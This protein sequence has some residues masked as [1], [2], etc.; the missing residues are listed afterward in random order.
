M[1]TS[2]RDHSCAVEL[3]RHLLTIYGGFADKR[4]KNLDKGNRFIVDDRDQGQTRDAHGQLYPWFC[5]MALEVISPQSMKLTMHGNVPTSPSVESWID[6][7]NAVR[8][9]APKG[10]E[11]SIQLGE[12]ARL[13]GL[14]DLIDAIVKPPARYSVPSYKYVCPRTATALRTLASALAK[15][16]RS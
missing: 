3:K 9:E 5:Q 16:P 8:I 15:A 1:T 13:V 10:L 6:A 4:I 11:L 2:S 7:N 14:A 12:E